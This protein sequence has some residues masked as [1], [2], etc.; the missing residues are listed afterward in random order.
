VA[1]SL[2]DLTYSAITVSGAPPHDATK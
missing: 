2:W 1:A